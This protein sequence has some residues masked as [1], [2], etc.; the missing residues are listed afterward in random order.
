MANSVGI[1][2]LKFSALE[3]VLT[4]HSAPRLSPL[5]FQGSILSICI[6]WSIFRNAHVTENQAKANLLKLLTSNPVLRN[7]QHT[8]F[9]FSDMLQ[10][11]CFLS[12]FD[13]FSV[14]GLSIRR[15][16]GFGGFDIKKN[17]FA[18]NAVLDIIKQH[19]RFP[20]CVLSYFSLV[21][22]V[23]H[24]RRWQLHIGGSK[25]FEPLFRAG[26]SFLSHFFCKILVFDRSKLNFRG[27]FLVW[28]AD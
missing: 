23:E 1:N 18:K 8:S 24:S 17:V 20:C 12:E 13:S 22:V 4:E 9:L 5:Q 14:C 21:I 15:S 19:S 7:T 27:H 10:E 11:S 3:A 28:S 26:L 6:N 16:W 25:M 2:S